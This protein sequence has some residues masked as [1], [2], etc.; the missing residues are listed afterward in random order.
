MAGPLILGSKLR[1]QGLVCQLTVCSSSKR[2]KKT[3]CFVV[4]VMLVLVTR[5]KVVALTCVRTLELGCYKMSKLGTFP[6][7]VDVFFRFRER[8]QKW[9]K[10]AFGAAAA[11]GTTPGSS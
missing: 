5:C 11:T 9:S 10:S 4:F 2:G 7:A 3:N 6:S 8:G 1:F